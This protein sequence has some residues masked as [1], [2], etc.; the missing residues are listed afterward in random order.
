MPS[1]TVPMLS[2]A[3]AADC[4]LHPVHGTQLGDLLAVRCEESDPAPF[5]IC[6]VQA[7]T[8]AKPA[9]QPLQA[10]AFY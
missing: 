10:G 6:C 4:S 2:A 3:P 1:G 9:S 7:K 8:K 5:W